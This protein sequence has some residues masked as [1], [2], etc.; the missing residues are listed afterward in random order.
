MSNESLVV[1]KE[2]SKEVINKDT[3]KVDKCFKLSSY[4]DGVVYFETVLIWSL[5]GVGIQRV[6]LEK[7]DVI[8]V[9]E[10]KHM[11]VW[12]YLT[13]D[14]KHFY[15]ARKKSVVT[16]YKMNGEKI[17]KFNDDSKIKSPYGITID[18]DSNITRRET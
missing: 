2:K 9:V 5:Y 1:V 14:G 15:H 6:D 10:E 11:P 4:P 7:G 12:T 16:C 3:E 13:T 18:N 17:W 8:T